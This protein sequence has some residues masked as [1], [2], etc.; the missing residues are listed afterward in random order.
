M[1]PRLAPRMRNDR[2]VNVT[3]PV[4]IEEPSFVVRFL[5]GDADTEES[6]A[7]VDAVVDLPD[8]SSWALTLFS[9]DEV[10][11]LLDKWRESGEF[12]SGSYFWAIDQVIVPQPGIAGMTDAIRELVRT[13]NITS[14]A[15]RCTTPRD[16]QAKRA[17]IGQHR[18]IGGR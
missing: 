13:G 3:S 9:V 12:A 8:G 4:V 2:P 10:R 17:V 15:I 18:A 11:R 14:A 7:N 5:L 6:V 1:G 16:K